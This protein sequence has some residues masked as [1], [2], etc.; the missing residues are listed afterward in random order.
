MWHGVWEQFCRRK[1]ALF[2]LCL[3]SFFVL[4]G[5]Y[6]P[7]LASNKP[8]YVVYGGKSYFPLF[9]YL[10]YPGFFTKGVDRFYNGLMLLLPIG[11]VLGLVF[12]RAWVF[13]AMCVAQLALFCFLEQWPPG[14]PAAD[15]DLQVAREEALLKHPEQTWAF[16]LQFMSPY[17]KL[18]AVLRL[19]QWK[20]RYEHLSKRLGQEIPPFWQIEEMRCATPYGCSRVLWLEGEQKKISFMMMPLLRPFHWEEDAGG[21]QQLNRLLPW[22]ELTRINRKDLVASLL[23]GVRISLLVGVAV[24][25][26]SLLIGVPFGAASGYYGGRLDMWLSRFL[27]IWESMPVFFL[28]LMVVAIL[29]TKSI[30]VVIGVLAIFGWTSYGRYLRA[31]VLKQRNLPYV[32]AC[33][34]IGYRSRQILFRHILPNAISPLLTLLPFSMMAAITAEAGVSFLGLGEEGSTSWGVLM[35]EGRSAFPA[36]SYLLWPPA[37]FLTLLL[38]AIAIVGDVLR[39]ALDPRLRS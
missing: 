2:A 5:I 15:R 31:E 10:F 9:R 27:E 7:F 28:L 39:D 21:S 14:D 24:V 18:N 13:W 11:I 26:L 8:L 34:A 3:L 6:A 1:V 12:R 32:E 38:V 20:G 36:E 23:F 25:C 30:F 35:D 33:Q 17:A 16:D 29:Q 19:H 4:I 22:W 37:V